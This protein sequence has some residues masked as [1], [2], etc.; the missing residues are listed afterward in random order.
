V[1]PDGVLFEMRLRV[2]TVAPPPATGF[3]QD[4]VTLP[5]SLVFVCC[6]D[7]AMP[8]IFAQVLLDRAAA[9]LDSSLILGETYEEVVGLVERVLE[10]AARLG[11]DR[12]LCILDQ[13][14]DFD[15]GSITG[16]DLVGDLRAR[17]FGG[18]LVIQ[19]ANDEAE[20]K[21][22]YVA[23]GADG[24]IGKAVKGGVP[25]MISHLAELWDAKYGAGRRRGG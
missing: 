16:T 19:S 4:A 9:D 21:R 15:A 11:E 13:N 3:P 22:G 12:I 23:A 20:D 1:Q 8:R 24:S 2:T 10:M 18:L 17:G 5:E 7:D 14:I 25:E 6:D